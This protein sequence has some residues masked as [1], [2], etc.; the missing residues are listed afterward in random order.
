MTQADITNITSPAKGAP[1][2][3]WYIDQ[4]RDVAEFTTI[5]AAFHAWT[6]LKSEWDYRSNLT[7]MDKLGDEMLDAYDD[8]IDRVR[9]LICKMPGRGISDVVS[10]ID[11]LTDDADQFVHVAADAPDVIKSVRD[12]LSAM[13]R[14]EWRAEDRLAWAD[15]GGDRELIALAQ[16]LRD[17]WGDG[18][19]P[20]DQA[21]H[22]AYMEAWIADEERLRAIR[23]ATVRGALAKA[24]FAQWYGREAGK[25]PDP[26]YRGLDAVIGDLM[27]L[28]GPPVQLSDHGAAPKHAVELSKAKSIRDLESSLCDLER[29]AQVCDGLTGDLLE[30]MSIAFS[31][32]DKAEAILDQCGR[33]TTMTQ[34]LA[35]QVGEMKA[36]FYQV[37]FPE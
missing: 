24:R 1:I 3:K 14:A 23:P 18:N 21:E 37:A 22:A 28:V 9:E 31:E 25:M 26:I 30:H 36:E 33:L 20:A 27:R 19:G 35:R 32:P 17:R 8:E 2:R 6:T 7:P 12:D 11:L 4:I 34:V 10:K 29:L 5:S 13:L 16:E 15:A